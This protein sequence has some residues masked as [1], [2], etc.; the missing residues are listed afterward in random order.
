MENLRPIPLS[1]RVVWR[2]FRQ[3]VL[4]I[5]I[6]VTLVALTAGLWI[7]VGSA[8]ALA[9][10]AEGTRSIVSSPQ[11]G[12][13]VELKVRPYQLV[14]HGDIIAIIQ[15]TDPRITLDLLQTELELARMRHEPTVAQQN[16]MDYQ[17]IRVD[18]LR[19]KS[20]LAVARVN[21]T[22]ANDDLKRNR[23]LFEEKLISEELYGLYLGTRDAFQAEVTEKEAT[24]RDIEQRLSDLRM[25]GDPTV[26]SQD[27]DRLVTQQM[28]IAQ[29]CA[30]SNWNAVTLL[31]PAS[32]M[33]SPIFRN[34]GENIQAGEP[35]VIIQ[36]LKSDRVVAYLRQ[37][38]PFDPVVGLSARITTRD[39]VRQQLLASITHVGPQVEPI[40]NALAFIRQG[41][42]VDVGLPIVFSLP[43]HSRIRPGELVDIAIS[44]GAN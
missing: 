42:L 30:V 39:R 32:G 4:P 20:E 3:Q 37:P 44:P 34:A 33:V 31:A 38:Y 6:F 1:P 5:C 35:L 17:R 41:A 18:Q 14:N 16:A 12:L 28:E 19:L 9:G 22:R 10:V 15:P 29:A 13:L 40:T 43:P 25:L 21:L 11:S 23:A 26:Q 24:I 36:S 27:L 8:P 2:Q 7:K